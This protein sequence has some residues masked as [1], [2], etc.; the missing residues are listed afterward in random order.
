[1]KWTV[2]LQIEGVDGKVGEQTLMEI[3]RE[4]ELRVERLGLALAEAK[5]LLAALQRQMVAAQVDQYGSEFRNCS[6]CHRAFRTKGYYRAFFRSVFGKVPIRVRRLFSC[7]CQ[8][9]KRGSFSSLPPEFE[10][11]LV[12]PEWKFLQAKLA[13]LMPYGRVGEL[14]SE[15]FP[16]DEGR[17]A[18]TVRNR[19]LEVGRRLEEERSQLQGSREAASVE[20]RKDE[21]PHHEPKTGEIVLGLDGG[22]VRNRHPRPERNFEVVAGKAVG[23]EGASRCFAFVRGQG[24]ALECVREAVA[25]MGANL[26]AE[27]TVLTDGDSGLREI[28]KELAPPG[29]HLLDWFHLAMRFQVLTQTAKG[30]SQECGVNVRGWVM[31][32]LERA[33]WS[34]WHG[35]PS[36]AWQ[37]LEDLYG[38]T[39][40]KRDVTPVP[41]LK[42]RAGVADLIRYLELNRDSIPDYGQRYRS[43][44]IISTAMAESAVNQVVSRR[45]IKKQQMRWSRWGAQLLLNVR[46]QVL[47]GE[48]QRS[49]RR[50]YPEFDLHEQLESAA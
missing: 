28:Q 47:N 24:V 43:G 35:R 5:R 8:G 14:L 30:L 26:D 33:K 16:V 6:H 34:L 27:M 10:H 38:W 18:A 7:R 1:M 11:D 23:P 46:T 20:G 39:C 37:R 21:S 12:A 3:E 41:V 36:A 31:E 13:S 9:E 17:N 32:S 15:L 29:T 40:A 2:K 50:W 4:D 48:L 22:Y 42:L 44:K 49:F 45:M 25:A 19:T